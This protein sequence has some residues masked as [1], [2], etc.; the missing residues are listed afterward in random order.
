MKHNRL[1]ATADNAV[2]CFQHT[3]VH[4]LVHYQSSFWINSLFLANNNEHA[5]YSRDEN[6]SDHIII[7]IIIINVDV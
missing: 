5:Q 2:D 3:G 7:I 6:L 1:F 4:K